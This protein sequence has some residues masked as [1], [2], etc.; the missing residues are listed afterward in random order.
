MHYSDLLRYIDELEFANHLLR[1]LISFHEF[2]HV[3]VHPLLTSVIFSAADTLTISL[4]VKF[5][6]DNTVTTFEHEGHENNSPVL[7]PVTA[8]DSISVSSVDSLDHIDRQHVE[9]ELE[10]HGFDCALVDCLSERQASPASSHSFL[11]FRS[12]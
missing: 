12:T 3:A 1:E 7:S 5:S 4:F 2:Q 9:N 11:S 10:L 6:R 8:L